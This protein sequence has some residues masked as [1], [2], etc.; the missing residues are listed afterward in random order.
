MP[1]WKCGC[2]RTGQLTATR[3]TRA[4]RLIPTALGSGPGTDVGECDLENENI[5]F[6]IWKDKGQ[7]ENWVGMGKKIG[8]RWG[9]RPE[10]GR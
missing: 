6:V 8:A 2:A 5:S 1:A 4:T 3:A 9:S 10:K 7:K